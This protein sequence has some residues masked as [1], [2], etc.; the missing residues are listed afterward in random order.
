MSRGQLRI[1]GGDGVEPLIEITAARGVK[2]QVR[3]RNWFPLHESGSSGN[4]RR[5][6]EGDVGEDLSGVRS[7]RVEGG[8]EGRLVGEFGSGPLLGRGRIYIILLSIIIRKHGSME[9]RYSIVLLATHSK[10]THSHIPRWRSSL[11]P[12]FAR[13]RISLTWSCI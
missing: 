13:L 9:Y 1:K 3:P 10:L 8:G 5:R 4:R 7:D 6:G 12:P 2:V 11:P